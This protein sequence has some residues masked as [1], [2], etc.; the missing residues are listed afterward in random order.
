[1]LGW[2]ACTQDPHW[3]VRQI[4]CHP[5]SAGWAQAF[6][7]LVAIGFAYWLGRKQMLETRRI[8]DERRTAKAKALALLFAPH[9]ADVIL[10]LRRI[11]DVINRNE[12]GMALITPVISTHESAVISMSFRVS[13][14]DELLLRVDALPAHAATLVVQLFNYIGDFNDFVDEFLPLSRRFNGDERA[15]F[16]E[17]IDKKFNGIEALV[18]PTKDALDAITSE[19]SARP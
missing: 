13:R 19:I 3:L 1:M 12:H 11:Q 15:A 8:D 16:V 14:Y 9:L 6:G 10:E 17:D 2:D 4:E 7:T 5:G 18:R